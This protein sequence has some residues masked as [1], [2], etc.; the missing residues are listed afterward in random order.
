MVPDNEFERINLDE[1]PTFKAL[2]TNQNATSKT[3]IS[4]KRDKATLG[5]SILCILLAVTALALAIIDICWRPILTPERLVLLG[6]A[7][8]LALLPFSAKFKALGVEWERYQDK[9]EVE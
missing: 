1:V 5:F 3:K 2:V 6:F 9:R 4:A 7:A 8:G